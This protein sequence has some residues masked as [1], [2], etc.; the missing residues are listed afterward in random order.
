MHNL[1]LLVIRVAL[2]LSSNSSCHP[3]TGI[4]EKT[5]PPIPVLGSHSTHPSPVIPAPLLLSSQYSSPVI[6]SSPSSVI[7]VLGSRI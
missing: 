6:Q 1:P 7:P 2:F 4:Q 3:S 5:R